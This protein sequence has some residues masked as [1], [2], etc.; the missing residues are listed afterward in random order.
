[1]KAY[2]DSEIRELA[3]QPGFVDDQSEKLCPACGKQAV[4]SYVYEGSRAGRPVLFWRTWCHACRRMCSSVGV[5]PK[6]L[7]FDDP[8]VRMTPD[9]R[10]VVSADSDGFFDRLDQLW[11]K[12]TLPQRFHGAA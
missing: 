4:R 9:E 6:R 1:M 10:R 3:G 2:T 7:A 8:F 11:R 12:G 5:K